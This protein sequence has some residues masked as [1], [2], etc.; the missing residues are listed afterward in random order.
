MTT[1]KSR[2]SISCI[3]ATS[4]VAVSSTLVIA[5]VNLAEAL[6]KNPGYR[7]TIVVFVMCMVIFL[8]LALNFAFNFGRQPS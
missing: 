3:I 8:M 1:T 7:G 6:Q 2:P 5:W 4:L